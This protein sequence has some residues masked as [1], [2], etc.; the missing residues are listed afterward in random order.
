MLCKHSIIAARADCTYIAD[1]NHRSKV[2]ILN[3][4][5]PYVKFYGK[6]QEQETGILSRLIKVIGTKIYHE[7]RAFLRFFAATLSLVCFL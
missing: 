6:G 2:Y 7:R 4:C 1:R 3:C 5:R